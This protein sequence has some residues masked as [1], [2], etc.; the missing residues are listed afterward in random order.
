MS[1]DIIKR[2]KIPNTINE[3]IQ[4]IFNNPLLKD[5]LVVIIANQKFE[6]LD[7]N[8]TGISLFKYNKNDLLNKSMERLFDNEQ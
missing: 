8:D 3:S 5:G 7:I 4:K 1:E 6:I 2:L